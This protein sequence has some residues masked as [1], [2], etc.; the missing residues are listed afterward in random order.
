MPRPVTRRAVA[1]LLLAAP[2]AA[3]GT[4][5]GGSAN[6]WAAPAGVTPA[7]QDVDDRTCKRKADDY[8]MRRVISPGRVGADTGH[9]G[10]SPMIQADRAK[11]GDAFRRYYRECMLALGYTPK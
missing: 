8:A 1:I 3:C 10:N 9:A 4:S 5:G 11:A 6:R 2:L 7:R